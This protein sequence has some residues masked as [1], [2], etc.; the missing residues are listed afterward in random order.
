MI[1]A[2]FDLFDRALA[3]ERCWMR[4]AD[5]TRLRLPTGRWL[6]LAGAGEC[7]ADHALIRC[8]DG[9]TVDLGCGPGRLVAALLRRGVLALGIDISPTAVAISRFRGAPALRRD[10][11]GP[12]PG[13]G[14]W[15]YAILADGNIGI[16]GDPQR[17]LARTAELLTPDGVAIVEFGPPGAGSVTRRVRLESRSH[18]GS[19]FSWASV[20]IDHAE[21]LAHATGF[22][23]LNTAGVGGR[24]IAWLLRADDTMKVN[25][26]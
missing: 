5:G 16:G 18:V 8:C 10:L 13:A 12:L 2:D 11:F 17:I 15:S 6:G 23:V 20:G 14:R 19:W 1:G 3:G 4:A 26:R 25:A 9:P 7:R 22:R 24:H 21:Q